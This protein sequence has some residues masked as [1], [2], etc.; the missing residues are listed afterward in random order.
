MFD[1]DDDDEVSPKDVAGL[2]STTISFTEGGMLANSVDQNPSVPPIDLPLAY[3]NPKVV[4]QAVLPSHREESTK[5]SFWSRITPK[6]KKASSLRGMNALILHPD[7]NQEGNSPSSHPESRVVVKSSGK[8]VD[9]PV[10][11]ATSSGDTRAIRR[12]S[13]KK[14]RSLGG[15]IGEA[16]S[17]FSRL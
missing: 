6:V 15:I 14:G 13:P 9:V 2:I 8:L 7:D 11:P 10:R 5:K 4:D 1:F 12:S 3:S 16:R 17:M